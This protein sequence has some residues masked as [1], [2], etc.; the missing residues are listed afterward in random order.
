FVFDF[1]SG[2]GSVVVVIC[3]EVVRFSVVI[4]VV[5]SGVVTYVCHFQIGRNSVL[6]VVSVAQGIERERED[7]S[8]VITYFCRRRGVIVSESGRDKGDTESAAFKSFCSQ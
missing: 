4:G 5:I 2:N 8:A 3:I 6:V 1:F 7:Q